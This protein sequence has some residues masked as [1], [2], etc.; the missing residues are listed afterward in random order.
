MN[1]QNF[2]SSQIA[3]RQWEWILSASI[4]WND[5]NAVIRWEQILIAKDCEAPKIFNLHAN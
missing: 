5:L 1:C 2:D 3:D 4:Y